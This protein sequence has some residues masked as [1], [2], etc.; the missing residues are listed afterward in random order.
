M[1]IKPAKSSWDY[2]REE[3]DRRK[4][5]LQSDSLGELIIPSLHDAKRLGPGDCEF[6]FHEDDMTNKPTK[7][8]HG[9]EGGAWILHPPIFTGFSPQAIVPDPA[10]APIKIV[11]AESARR[12][13]GQLIGIAVEDVSAVISG[14]V[15]NVSIYGQS[16]ETAYDLLKV[17]QVEVPAY[18]A[19]VVTNYARPAPEPPPKPSPLQ[20]RL[21]NDATQP[22]PTFCRTCGTTRRGF[23][24]PK[25][26][27]AVC[28]PCWNQRPMKRMA[29]AFGA[30]A[31]A[32][33]TRRGKRQL[34]AMAVDARVA[35]CPADLDR[36]AYRAAMVGW[37]ELHRS[38]V[39]TTDRALNGFNANCLGGR[40]F[41]Y[42]QSLAARSAKP[43]GR[44][45]KAYGSEKRRFW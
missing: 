21:C 1:T 6:T 31:E 33:E 39:F 42:N 20:N 27:E 35:S 23:V 12:R 34:Q 14:F 11:D 32:M 26:G 22:W 30:I 10:E 40:D 9:D 17:L 28:F 3:L 36:E 38:D 7:T 43:R 45:P 41:L 15:L 24:Y 2:L 13:I 16:S 18:L 5:E 25:P 29:E 4:L 19:V 37:I 8:I 44:P